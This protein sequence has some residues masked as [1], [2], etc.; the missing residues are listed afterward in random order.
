MC[1]D[2]EGP[3]TG[4]GGWG[5]QDLQARL[6]GGISRSSTVVLSAEINGR[7]R[8][9]FSSSE[10][11]LVIAA[12]H[13]LL[14]S[15]PETVSGFN[16]SWAAVRALMQS[17]FVQLVASQLTQGL[18][19]DAGLFN[20]LVVLMVCECLPAFSG[21]VQRDLS[22][23]STS[24]SYVFSDAVSALLASAG[25]PLIAASLGMFVGGGGLFS[26]TLALTGVNTLCGVAF[27]VVAGGSLALAW[28]VALL[29][30]AVEAGR[31]FEAV[32]PFLD[33][34][35]YRAS[36]AVYGGLTGWRGGG[37][38]PDVVGLLFFF[39]LL[40]PQA[41]GAR[42]RDEVWTGVCVLVLVRAASDWF[43]TGIMEATRSDAVFG[44]LCIATAIHF[45]T[46]AVETA[47]RGRR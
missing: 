1:P 13:A 38:R 24:V 7:L 34:G 11:L 20:L 25:V 26:Q 28:P 32:Q 19:P 2:E 15:M 31:S 43:L 36:D 45:T 14:S 16:A 29:Y 8:M 4:G 42:R 39:L 22:G 3:S 23:L 30:F 41:W 18:R 12:V 9:Y 5:G 10:L 6:M 40:L 27:G 37:L 46:V 35:L 44:G 33:Y 21:W 17:L 47:C